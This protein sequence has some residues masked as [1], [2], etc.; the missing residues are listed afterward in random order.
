MLQKKRGLL[1][2]VKIVEPITRA[3]KFCNIQVTNNFLHE[4]N[5]C[6]IVGG[7][8][9]LR[10]LSNV[11]RMVFPQV[12]LFGCLFSA[13]AMCQIFNF[14]S[15]TGLFMTWEKNLLFLLFF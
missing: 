9:Y 8:S 13:I 6:N 2:Q 14:V 4:N 11:S 10:V 15:P 1:S 3:R 5:N 7:A 12:L